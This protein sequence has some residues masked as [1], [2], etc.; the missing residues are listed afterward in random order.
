VTN[1]VAVKEDITE[2]KIRE[3]QLFRLN[4]TLKA[5]RDSNEAILMKQILEN[6]M[7]RY[8]VK[9]GITGWAQINGYRGGTRDLVKM[10]KRIDTDN[11]YMHNWTI[12]LD[13]QII[14]YT[15]LKFFTGDNNAY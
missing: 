7:I 14:F 6:Y 5:M 8:Y 9:P 10:Q 13:I 11:W 2:R 12:G 4:R 3:E 1:Y 15:V